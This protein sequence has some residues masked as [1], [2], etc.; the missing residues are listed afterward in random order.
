MDDM[1]D[2]FSIQNLV[3]DEF[4]IVAMPYTGVDYSYTQHYES[5][6]GNKWREWFSDHAYLCLPLT[7]GNQ[8]GFVV[9]S[10]H[11]F[12]ITWNGGRG[13]DA[14]TVNMGEDFNDDWHGQQI[15]SHFGDGIVTIQNGFTLRT[16]DKINLMTINPPNYFI[17]GLAHMT[18][19]VECDNLRRDFT[20]NLKLTRKDYTVSIK[21]GDWIG[22][23]IPVPRYFV[24][25]HEMIDA[26]DYLSPKV[27]EEERQISKAFGEERMGDDL[28]KSHKAGR[29]YFNGED[30]YDNKFTDHQKRIK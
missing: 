27:I 25:N 7:I 19:V 10:N 23:F 20:F 18:G 15:E 26:K 9:K 4:K 17:D 30:V 3:K 16:S 2:S 13:I 11:A 12:D 21:K 29:R 22:C 5:L 28:K 6:V 14:T 8:Y 24:E 1:L